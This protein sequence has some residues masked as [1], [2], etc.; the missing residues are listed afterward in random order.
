MATWPIALGALVNFGLALYGLYMNDKRFALAGFT[1]FQVL[2]WIF[3][4]LIAK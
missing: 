2:A 1:A 4:A 3:V